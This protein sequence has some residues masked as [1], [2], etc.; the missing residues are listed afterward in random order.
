MASVNK[1]SPKKLLHSKWTA[2]QPRNKEKH[3]LVTAVHCDEEDYPQTVTLEAVHSQ[4]ET[5][6]DWRELKDS[7]GWKVGWQ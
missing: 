7:G 1:L 4:R 6:F 2:V 5:E 3:F